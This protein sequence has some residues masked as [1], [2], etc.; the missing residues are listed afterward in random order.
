MHW[1]EVGSTG[2]AGHDLV[3]YFGCDCRDR[4]GPGWNW[5]C[6]YHAMEAMQGRMVGL[7]SWIV[8]AFTCMQCTLKQV[9]WLHT[10]G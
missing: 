2:R 8:G 9:A 7:D 6:K 4:W 1:G 5:V 10:D 3:D